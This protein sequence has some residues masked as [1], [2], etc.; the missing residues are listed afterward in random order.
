[1]YSGKGTIDGLVSMT[2]ISELLTHWGLSQEEI[3][4]ATQPF[5]TAD[6]LVEY[7]PFVA[8]MTDI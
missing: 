7:K 3:D 8:A 1:M 6:N 2:N 5:R 4:D